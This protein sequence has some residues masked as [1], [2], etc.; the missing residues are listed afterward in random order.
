MVGWEVKGEGRVEGDKGAGL[1]ERE[2]EGGKG[3]D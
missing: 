1:V 2:G 3:E